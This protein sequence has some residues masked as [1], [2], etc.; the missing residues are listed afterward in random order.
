MDWTITH[1]GAYTSVS[2][3][4]LV[5]KALDYFMIDTPLIKEMSK[6]TWQAS[7]TKKSN[8]TELLCVP[9]FGIREFLVE[10]DVSDINVQ[11][12]IKDTEPIQ[13]NSSETALEPHEYQVAIVDRL[14][15]K[16]FNDDISAD[17][18]GGCILKLGAGFGK[19]LIGI[20]L[21]QKISRKTAVIVHSTSML[22]QWR[23]SF[24]Q[25]T[26]AK[27][28]LLPK[29][30]G[31]DKANVVIGCINSF[32]NKPISFFHQFGFIIY[33]ECHLYC[34]TIRSEIFRKA[35]AYRVLGISA[36]PD[37]RLDGFGTIAKWWL[38]DVEDCQRLADKFQSTPKF[39]GEVVAIKYKGDPR[40]TKIIRND[41]LGVIDSSRTIKQITQDKHRLVAL[42][43]EIV[44][45]FNDGY[46]TF[47]F[48]D[49]KSYLE[50]INEIIRKEIP[51][52]K[53]AYVTGGASDSELKQA[54]DEAMVILSTYAYM[55]VGKSIKK[56]TALVLATPRR[57][58]GE[59]IN[60]RI[61][62]LGSDES[63]KRRIVD[64]IDVS[65]PSLAR[66]WYFRNKNYKKEKYAII[67][68]AINYRDVDIKK[69]K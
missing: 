9:R 3:S 63:V 52:K 8:G 37:A 61:F 67:N 28:A 17:G 55:S 56:M 60:K 4:D 30:K 5:S 29:S 25:A 64:L 6:T 11:L 53:I 35:Q 41:K 46:N 40:Y 13:L 69:V 51:D 14:Y 49:R 2:D 36:T 33:D 24:N 23:D 20:M 15:D 12:S 16:Y 1:S 34:S 68:K 27:V 38:G 10:R 22:Y 48:A 59:Q 19:S 18:F 57:S 26:N 58:N 45:T 32:L 42:C 62:R 44:N 65:L 47:V 21:A 39:S 31:L 54:E 50:S 43:A 66:Q 7:T